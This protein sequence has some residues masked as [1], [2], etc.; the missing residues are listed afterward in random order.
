MAHIADLRTNPAYLEGDPNIVALSDLAGARTFVIVPMLRGA[1]LVGTIGVYRQEVRPFSDKQIELLSNFAKQAVIAIENTRLLKEL[2]ERTE[3]L[4]ESLQQQTATANV[5]KVI[6][7]S[8]FDLQTVLQ[9]LVESAAR[10]CEADLANIW[11][12]EGT[13]FHLA[14]SFGIPGKDK[15]K[16]E[17]IKYLESISIEPGRGSMVGRV[18]LEKRPVQIH[19][20]QADPE[21]ELSGVIRIGNYRTALGVPLLREGVPIGVIFLSRCTVRP[22]TDKHIELVTTFADQA[23]IAIENVRLFDEVQARTRDLSESLQEQT[24]TADVL[25]IISSSP[26]ELA[27]VF[28][29]ML[30]NATRV[31]GA[32]FGQMNLYEAGGFRPVAHY[33]VPAAYAA[34]LA[35]TPFQPHPQSGLGTVARTHQV[36]HIGDIRTLPPY[37]EG[38]P[39]VVAIADLAG[40]RTYFVVPMLKENELIGAI[41]IYRQEVK[42]FTDK[43]I[44]LVSNFAN[45]AVIAIE[46]TR[47]LKELR[48]R[49]DDL[50]ESLEQQTATSEVLQ[51]ISSSPGEL[52]PIFQT[53]L[54][55][56]TR[57]CEANFGMMYRYDNGA[58]HP[59]ALLN[60]PPALAKYVQD[61]GSFLPPPGTPLDR[62]FRTKEVTY[63]ADETAGSNPG[64]PARLGGARS[65]VG[66]PM[67]KENELVGAIIIYRQEVR[68]FTDKQVELVRGFASQAVIAIENTRLLKELRES[69]QQQT[70]TADVLKV[71]S[72]ST[73]ELETVLDTLVET[74]AR[75]CRADQ[76]YMFRRRDDK[77]HMLAAC[78]LTE[79]A[80]DFI[81]THP[82][83][84]DRGTIS[85]RVVMER[86]A[87]HVPDVLQDPEFTYREGQKLAG[88]R[89]MLGIPL[90]REDAL[91]GVFIVTRTRVEPFTTKEIELATS[92]ADQ[93][94]IAIENARLFEELRD[95][96]A[97]LRVTFDNMGDGVVMFDAQARLTAWN[98]NFQ[99]MLELPDAVLARRPSYADYFRYLADHGEYSSDL[100]AELSRT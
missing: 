56:A 76:A 39:S 35:H 69:L 28:Q 6:S 70:A 32:N 75:L 14:A 22:F 96:Q 74:V 77:Y 38:N 83:A 21:Y 92:F 34:L 46:N 52:D 16:L 45:Q 65:L 80:K 98:R 78:G 2:R 93:A 12:P 95:R 57:I 59:A 54:A 82:F 88:A 66:V 10:L 19:D 64:V 25:K 63:T 68:P 51:V 89:T 99:E 90:L 44:A 23:V 50:S 13:A 81:L 62:L 1:E 84:V 36:V 17:N 18:L 30:E 41:T 73:V 37:L 94:V 79:E 61:R 7:R 42:P 87:V 49:T 26:G 29:S 47:L 58:F 11:R 55:K 31:C 53:M 5:L 43:Q 24:A 67:L 4:S 3:D 27:P 33:N 15:E 86:R 91:I 71:I 20:I 72:R 97:E 60:V 48:Q 100:E 85:G 40:A 9:T 8:T